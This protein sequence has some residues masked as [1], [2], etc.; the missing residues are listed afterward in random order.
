MFEPIAKSFLSCIV[1]RC[2]RPFLTFGLI[3]LGALVVG[4]S[5]ADGQTGPNKESLIETLRDFHSLLASKDFVG[6]S[7]HVVLPPKFKP[8]ML[9]QIIEKREISLGG[10]ARLENEATF[11]KAAKTSGAERASRF[12]DRAGV[13]VEQCYGFYFKAGDVEAEVIAFWD[14]SRFKLVRFDDIGKLDPP[15]QQ[16]PMAGESDSSGK[17][18]P[19]GNVVADLGAL[20]SAV[21]SAPDD[22]GA[23]A[24]YAQALFKVGNLPESWLQIVEARKLAPKHAGIAKGLSVI[25]AGFEKRGVFSVGVPA[26]SVEAL[27]GACDK[28]IDLGNGRQ[29]LVYAFMGVDLKA[30][31]VHEV[32]DLRGATKELFEPQEIVS[33]DLGNGGW[34]CGYRKKYRGHSSAFYFVPGE[35][36]GDWS[37]EF[38]VERILGGAK[39]GSID[40]I[41]NRMMKQVSGRVPSA[42][43]TVLGRDA[44]SALIAMM[45]P[46]VEGGEAQHKLVRLMKGPVDLHR[47]VF[48]LK[49]DAPGPEIQ[50]KWAAIL[51]SAKLIEPSAGNAQRR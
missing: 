36:V 48:V 23:R 12:A 49:G 38:I 44:D 10:I 11:A 9:G 13:D 29:R 46:G 20:K 41:V 1:R 35:S 45:I 19:N 28:K 22:V 24:Q 14:G 25:F 8:E 2:A 43:Q 32:I 39:I 40:E 42:K 51:R 18:P 33:V 47:V 15:G 27:L 34:R 4:P 5:A 37:K 50:Q 7:K 31:R 30:G 21:D 16:T 17:R 3:V 26:E 6:A